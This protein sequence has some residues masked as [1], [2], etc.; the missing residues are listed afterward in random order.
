MKIFSS[1]SGGA[2]QRARRE[3]VAIERGIM[4]RRSS[5]RYIG[6]HAVA[7][8]A[9][10]GLPVGKQL[11]GVPERGFEGV[12][13]HRCKLHAGRALRRQR[14]LVRI[15]NGVGQTTHSRDNRYRAVAQRTELGEPA[16]LEPRG[17]DE[18]VGARLNQMRKRLVIADEATDP[19]RMG[20]LGGG[21]RLLKIVIADAQAAQVERR[22]RATRG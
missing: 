18:R 14:H 5:P 12:G 1:S 20:R 19:S 15:D 2:I 22:A 6:R 17:D 9:G 10:P 13:V 7:L 11:R 21:E 8:H 16:R 4:M 3:Q